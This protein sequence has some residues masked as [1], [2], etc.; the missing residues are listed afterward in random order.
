MMK[1]I[2]KVLV[3]LFVAVISCCTLTT[4]VNA[5]PQTIQ[6]GNP[7]SIPGYVAGVKFTTKTTTSGELMYC[8]NIH[9][10]TAKNSTAKLVGELDAG[11][12]YIMVN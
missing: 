11:V 9:K 10:Y 5:V 2:K 8:L 4:T 6:L 3:A 7:E 1:K 12:A